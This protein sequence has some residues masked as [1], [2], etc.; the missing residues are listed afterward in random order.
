M[1]PYYEINFD[2][3]DY[4]NTNLGVTGIYAV[5][6]SIQNMLG[7]AYVTYLLI[8]K[9]YLLN[10][11]LETTELGENMRTYVKIMTL[12]YFCIEYV[13][14]FALILVLKFHDVASLT[15]MH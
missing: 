6:Y 11:Y 12:I 5:T 13:L 2:T 14:I 1:W 4:F 15:S 9:R 7:A 3:D 10:D 8:S